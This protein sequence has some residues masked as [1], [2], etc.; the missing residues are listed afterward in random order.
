MVS[1][2]RIFESRCLGLGFEK[3]F[4]YRS[5]ILNEGLGV[6]A[7][8]GF[9]HSIPLGIG[10]DFHAAA[11]PTFLSHLVKYNSQLTNYIRIIVE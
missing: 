7:S 4:K 6:S 8:L 3:N 2:T 11:P 1:R 5:Q 9:Y 10:P